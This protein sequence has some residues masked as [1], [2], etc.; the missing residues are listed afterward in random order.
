MQPD[1]TR[2]IILDTETTG[3]NMSGGAPHL[4]H[5]I[6]EIGCVEVI[7]RRL[8]GNH[9]HVYLNPD[10]PIDPEATTVHGITDDDV[11]DCPRFADVAEQFVE[12]IRGAELIA[13]NAPFDVGF[14]DHEFGKLGAGWAKTDELCQVTDSLVLAKDMYPGQKNNLDALCRRL[15]IDNSH[16]ELHGALLDAEILADVYL[17]MTG[18]QTKLALGQ[19]GDDG[20]AASAGEIRPVTLAGDALPVIKASS[21]EL[22]SHQETMARVEKKA[23]TSIWQTLG[24]AEST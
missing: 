3:M 21:T 17:L 20:S 14:M 19:D 6:I 2:Q 22:E 24:A 15:G 4:G 10:M 11:K 16:R 9:Y 5:R 23:G 12:F 7:N 18:G 1:Q 13:H 8:T